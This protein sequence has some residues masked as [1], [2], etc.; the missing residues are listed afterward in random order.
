MTAL[1][2]FA[3]GCAGKKESVSGLSLALVFGRTKI[4]E[5]EFDGVLA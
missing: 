4:P 3:T 2:C 1:V 5:G